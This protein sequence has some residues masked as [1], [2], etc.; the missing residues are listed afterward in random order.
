MES[1]K[2]TRNNILLVLLKPF[3]AKSFFFLFL[4]LAFI[5]VLIFTE[6]PLITVND[7]PHQRIL[8]MKW[9]LIPHIVFGLVAFVTGP[10]QFSSR[11]RKKNIALHRRLGKIY[12]AAVLPG[13]IFAVL[14][15]LNFPFVGGT[16]RSTF[17]IVMQSTL[18]F[19][20]TFLA[21]LAARNKQIPL[22][23]IWMARSYGVTFIFVTARVLNPVPAYFNLDADTASL[24]LWFLMILALT[25][26][27]ILLNWKE[28][29]TS[30]KKVA[31][32]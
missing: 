17:A 19:V 22:H 31:E 15:N 12:V 5:S 3:S 6:W 23:K 9:L 29:F 21:Y 13:A 32:K 20:T 8:T 18:W 14:V 30:K 27:E 4:G 11:L 25:V 28:F 24:F 10:F 26:P 1:Q 7:A 2:N 16:F